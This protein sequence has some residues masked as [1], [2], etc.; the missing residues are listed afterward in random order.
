M[1][2]RMMLFSQIERYSVSA[3]KI[4]EIKTIKTNNNITNEIK[5][6]MLGRLQNIK[7]CGK[8]GK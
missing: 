4:P 5:Y 8:C 6:D 1:L 7:P 3:S 2:P